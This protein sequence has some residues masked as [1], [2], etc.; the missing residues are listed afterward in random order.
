MRSNLKLVTT[1]GTGITLAVLALAACGSDDAASIEGQT[2]SVGVENAYPPYNFI[3]DATQEGAGFDY[4]IWRE[5]CARLSCT[6]TF[7]E[8][9]WPA[10]IEETGQGVYDTAADGI[11]ITDERKEV[12]DF[13]DPYMT[14]T[15]RFM[16]RD[17]WVTNDQ[18]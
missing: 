14:I 5:I 6:A 13:S 11:S 17:S 15:Q 18:R 2:I 10:V 16:V 12:V 8:A 3:D 9:G 1:L 4:D 7:V